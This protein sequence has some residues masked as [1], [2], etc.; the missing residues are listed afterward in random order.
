[1]SRKTAIHNFGVL[2]K[3]RKSITSTLSLFGV[4]FELVFCDFVLGIFSKIVQL[5]K[6]CATYAWTFSSGPDGGQKLRWTDEP[7]LI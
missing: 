1:M 7:R 4:C 5:I 2:L 3:E 6:A